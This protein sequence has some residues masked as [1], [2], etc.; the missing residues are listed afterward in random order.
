MGDPEP[1]VHETTE[2][3]GSEPEAT[4]AGLGP[5]GAPGTLGITLAGEADPGQAI[6]GVTLSYET[7]DTA[8]GVDDATH[9]GRT[10]SSPPHRP[11]PTIAG[12]LIEGELGRGAMGV[13]YLGR[14]VLLN[15]PCALKVILAGAHADPVAA[16]RFLGEAA[17]VARLQH[18]NIV[19]IHHVG[20]A[21]GL[22]FLELEYL[23]GGSLDRTLDGTPW[24]AR[25]AAALVE[26]LA[27]GVAEAHRLGIVH[28][29]LKP[30]NILLAADGT[31]KVADFGLAKSLNI[32]SGLTATDSIMGSPSY[33]APEQAEGKTKLVGPLADVYA[34]GA[35]LYE[36]LV[37]RP[38]F[39]GTTILETLEQVKTA[40]PVAPSRLLPGLPRDA[41]T[42]ALK[43]LPKD[44]ARRYASAAALAD[45]LRRYLDDEPIRARRLSQ[46][47]R[48]GR[49]AR[50]HKA[51]ASLL[52][53]LAA[54]LIVG[55]AIMAVLWTRAEQSAE[56]AHSNERTARTLA[57]KEADAR[58]EA[59]AQEKIAL[60][61]AEK[62]AQQDYINR[63]NRAYR[64]V[65]DDNVAQAEDLLHGC[66][67]ER[68]GW[69][70]H[71]VER[72][73]HAERL[74]LDLGNVSVNTLAFGPD[75][76][77]AVSG[78]GRA[79]ND[80]FSPLTPNVEVWDTA[81]GRRRRT[82]PGIKGT[83]YSVAVSPDGQRI[84]AGF[85][86]GLVLVWDSATGQI[87]WPRSVPPLSAM[88]VAFSPDSKS[89]AVGYGY[90]SGDQ[91]GKVE[92]REVASG[93]E[94]KSFPGPPGG[95]NKVAFDPAGK[96][97]AVA[98]S[99]VVAI[100]DLD[101]ATKVR[102]LPGHTKW[103]YS[104]AFSPDGKTLATGGWDRTVK[105]WD[106]DTG[107][108]RSTIFAH[109]G[110][111]VDLAFSPHGHNLA[112]AS[113]DRSLKLWDV[114]SG[115]LLGAFHGH[116]DFVQAVAFRPPGGREIA[117]GSLDGSLRFWDVRASRPVV[118]EHS[119]R[120][121]RL[122]V[123]RDG[124]R[125]LSEP[126]A[127]GT[128]PD[129]SK[130]WDPFTGELDPALTG[131]SFDALPDGF[132]VGNVY[133]QT[134]VSSPA[135]GVIAQFSPHIGSGGPIRSSKDYAA[136]AVVIR[137]A[138][139]GRV[140]HTLTGHTADVIAAMFSPDGR[141]LATASSDRTIK[142]WDTAT[143][144]DVFTLLGH[145]SGVRCLVF[146]PNGDL[147]V[148]G[149][150]D[151]MAR[152]WN[153]SPLPAEAT[154]EHDTR[155]QKKIAMLARLKVTT[156]DAQLAEVLAR[157]GRWGMAAIALGKAIERDPDQF[158]F[159]YQQ[160][161]LLLESGDL[162]G[163][164]RA[165]ERF[166]TRFGRSTYGYQL[167]CASRAC[168]LAPDAVADL[169]IPVR[170]AESAL[171]VAPKFAKRWNIINLGATLYRAGRLDEA[172]GRL[173]ESVKVGAGAADYRE[174]AFLAMA[175]QRKG[176]RA[177]ARRWLEKLRSDGP[178]IQPGF[179]WD[180]AEL[181]ILLREA[182]AL[183]QV[184]PPAHP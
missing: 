142:L 157:N 81:T 59:Q 171:A 178:S 26:A 113:E 40:E 24:P 134:T 116:T 135:G 41:E 37:G 11:A 20:E 76:S 115:R 79:P 44:P 85:S 166:S 98:G 95:V 170:L 36:L 122:A 19:Q 94:I 73:C 148:S 139:T 140:V 22:P 96:R 141:R 101:S 161:L 83:V 33:M 46:G 16:V 39:R 154:A 60:D 67:T 92:I 167:F 184:I 8:T 109:E 6:R 43:C 125:V 15:R 181:R 5:N 147:L 103:V 111:V 107:A 110:F 74:T 150:A 10:G 173:E 80:T 169:D 18:P 45:D 153:A 131:T 4:V 50:R 42:I 53:T 120:V 136:S 9:A 1:R 119:D 63:V 13:V 72:F 97:L 64:E 71:F 68:R 127:Y 17:A 144:R 124:L 175:H 112:T 180:F 56:I 89:L 132:V 2:A 99:G 48:L 126:T 155:Y 102:D 62:L 34:L 32:E 128:S 84:A 31:P 138:T 152:V 121:E 133:L 91:V 146:S 114:P 158:Q 65:Q 30:S 176:N 29:D 168:T 57:K 137:D 159:R 149:G 106:V 3:G 143:G 70:W 156:D 183:V 123:R 14:Q 51:V 100:W 54:V 66:P 87:A 58:A 93:E 164:R 77:W 47:E 182:E 163:Y 104:V 75:A 25:R 165:A 117:T 90:Y 82:L 172:I 69:E 162:P 177:E 179:S 78:S 160:L 12:Y 27:R 151:N 108:P 130:G 145:T 49:W 21:D 86:G 38:P 118:F 35:I 129:N 7:S 174:S 23:P 52:A 28:R 61:R 88:S 105:L 55:F